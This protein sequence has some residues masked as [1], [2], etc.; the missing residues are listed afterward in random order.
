MAESESILQIGQLVKILRGSDA[1]KFAVIIRIENERFVWIADGD[2]RKFDMPKKK[3]VLH[4]Q[5]F[6]FVSSEVFTSMAQTGRVANSKLRFAVNKF[7]EWLEA[8]RKK[9]E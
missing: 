1:G 5:A 6:D 8:Q 4:L 2:K 3:N 7:T 9:G